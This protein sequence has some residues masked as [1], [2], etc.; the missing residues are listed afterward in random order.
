MSAEEAKPEYVALYKQAFADYRAQALWNFRS[1]KNLHQ[2]MHW[3]WRAPCAL[4]AI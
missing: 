2:Q 1:L 3:L 4:K